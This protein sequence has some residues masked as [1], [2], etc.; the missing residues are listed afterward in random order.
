MNNSGEIEFQSTFRD[1]RSR[2]QIEE[3]AR[4]VIA[5]LFERRCVVEGAA[6][7]ANE[8]E[9]QP[10]LGRVMLAMSQDRPI[11]MVLPAFPG[12]STLSHLPDYAEQCAIDELNRL[13]EEIR[14]IHPP[15][16]KIKIC[17]DG[18]VFS[19]VVKIQDCHVTDYMAAIRDY[20]LAN[21]ADTFSM[22][23]L[24]DAFKQLRCL[25]SM[26]EELIVQYGVSFLTIKARIK[27]EKEAAS[28]YRGITR[29]LCEDYLG[30]P[31]FE[32]WSRTKIQNTARAAAYRVMH[33]SEAWS[34]LINEKFPDCLRLSIH[35]QFRV[36]KKIGIRL[37]PTSD[38]WRTP[39]HSVAVKTGD[40]V[41]L[42]KRSNVDE[43]LCVLVFRGGHPCHYVRVL[44]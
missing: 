4:A 35:P 30:L 20:C 10:H 3:V 43:R 42:E 34:D 9:I 23:D 14:Q 28:M 37:V 40:C 19:D 5:R 13:C 6:N 31:E 1:E 15:G 33:R 2:R 25:S 11:E 38:L 8:A 29:F 17:S 27:E 32:G 22:F 44:T 7:A 26:R 12:K 18:Y 16:A 39:W 36:S 41:Q 21:Y 24:I